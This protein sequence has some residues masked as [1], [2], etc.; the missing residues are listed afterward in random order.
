[1]PYRTV[2]ISVPLLFFPR[3]LIFLVDSQGTLTPLE[4]F[5]AYQLGVLLLALAA[6]SIM[7]VCSPFHIMRIYDSYATLQT[8]EETQSPEAHTG[9]SHPLMTPVTICAVL[10]SL[11]AWNSKNIG[12][13]GIFVCIGTGI[14]GAWGFWTV[15]IQI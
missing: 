12:S 6:G 9:A 3:F 14:V 4:Q 8:P 7:A 13:L 1:M 10:S 2:L 5:L 11:I 15:S